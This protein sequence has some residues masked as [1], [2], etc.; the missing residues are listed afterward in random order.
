[1][2][3]DNTLYTTNFRSAKSAALL[4]SDG[5]KPKFRELILSLNVNM[6]WFLPVASIE[7]ETIGACSEHGWHE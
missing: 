7:K 6:W 1:M 5:I 2:V 3:F 4:Q